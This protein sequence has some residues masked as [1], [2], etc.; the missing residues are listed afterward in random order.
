MIS[1]RG[2]YCMLRSNLFEEEKELPTPQTPPPS[3]QILDA[4]AFEELYEAGKIELFDPS[5]SSK[6]TERPVPT[7]TKL[8]K[9]AISLKEK[10]YILTS[11]FIPAIGFGLGNTLAVLIKFVAPVAGVGGAGL[12]IS[13]AVMIGLT[14]GFGLIA[15]GLM[16]MMYYS[17]Y[18]DATKKLETFNHQLERLQEEIDLKAAKILNDFNKAFAM[19]LKMK[20]ALEQLKRTREAL[21]PYSFPSHTETVIQKRINSY[22]DFLAQ[23]Q[24]HPNFQKIQDEFRHDEIEGAR[25]RQINL[26]NKLYEASEKILNDTTISV[27]DYAN[28][29]EEYVN[30][31]KNK[32]IFENG[33]VVLTKEG[34]ELTEDKVL[35]DS[36]FPSLHFVAPKAK[37][38]P[39]IN[40]NLKEFFTAFGS[41]FGPIFGLPFLTI[42][43]IGV[44]TTIPMAFP[45][46]WPILALGVVYGMY[47]VYR[48]NDIK[49]LD[50]E[51]NVEKLN[52]QKHLAY[53]H[54]S[55]NK[56]LKDR[57]HTELEEYTKYQ[58]DV[59]ATQFS[60]PKPQ[61]SPEFKKHPTAG[62]TLSQKPAVDYTPSSDQDLK[63]STAGEDLR[64]ND[65]SQLTGLTTN[66]PTPSLRP[67]SSSEEV[68]RP[69]PRS[70]TTPGFSVFSSSSN[71]NPDFSSSSQDLPGLEK[72]K[73][74]DLRFNDPS[75]LTNVSLKQA[76]A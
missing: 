63:I 75:Q 30:E 1:A 52:K 70:I 9:K 33:K 44:F 46:L 59:I 13:N 2:F 55:H 53:F 23:N 21:D 68:K 65:P 8:V 42:A 29:A 72:L 25:Q 27:K 5:P 16:G 49:K 35:R 71:R 24:N 61:P 58:Y 64:F 76:F 48:V 10:I 50:A 74:E 39:F 37:R 69:I 31:L 57:L 6:I 4:V 28:R 45:P 56:L 51:R 40:I 3:V 15:L 17:S 32:K 47:N 38:P 20:L 26:R 36:C 60:S 66:N 43:I 18:K 54:Y 67:T 73:D 7:A 19:L 22:I 11:S 41:A 12:Y 14:G 62:L 34:K